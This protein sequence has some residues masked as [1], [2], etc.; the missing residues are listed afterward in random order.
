MPGI[1]AGAGT[2]VG[3]AGDIGRR[4][5]LPW[6]KSVPSKV[7]R[8]MKALY[9]VGLGIDTSKH[10]TA[11]AC[12]V[13]KRCRVVL[14]INDNQRWLKRFNRNVVDLRRLYYTGDVRAIVY[15]RLVGRVIHET[16]DRPGV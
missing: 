14:H 16:R 15:E 7:K 10:V 2:S 4:S 11:E 9:L 1:G 12:A 3:V 8:S 6:W 13:L 5:D